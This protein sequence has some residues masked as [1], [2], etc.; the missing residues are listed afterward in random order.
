MPALSMFYGIIIRM[1]AEIGSQHNTPHFHA[2]YQG[3]DAS[4]DFDGNT[5]AGKLPDKQT[6]LVQAW[7]L[8]HRDELEANWELLKEDSN[9]FKIEPLR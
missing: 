3:K 5:L 6:R 8:L 9:F 4:F 2:G 7:A 1:Y